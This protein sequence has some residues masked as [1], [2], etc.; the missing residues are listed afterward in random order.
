MHALQP[1]PTPPL[2]GPAVT[3]AGRP[4]S[5]APEPSPGP[6]DYQQPMSP[7]REG[8]AFTI[9]ARCAV[10]RRR[11]YTKGTVLHHRKVCVRLSAPICL[12]V[13]PDPPCRPPQPLRC[14]PY[15]LCYV[16]RLD[17]K[18]PA[19]EVPAPGEYQLPTAWRTGEPG[20][21]PWCVGLG[22]R[23]DKGSSST[24]SQQALD[25]ALT[26]VSCT[27]SSYVSSLVT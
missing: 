21:R 2:P 26:T 13:R 22:I 4:R 19:A 25:V 11:R 18:N 23:Y 7:G 5:R 9:Y 3:I 1:L 24:G 10:T 15:P 20:C 14:V 8:P 16:P 6:M 27:R 12:L 17:Q